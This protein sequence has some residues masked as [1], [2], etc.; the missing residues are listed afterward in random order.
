[1][2]KLFTLLLLSLSLLGFNSS[3]YAADEGTQA[4]ATEQS[5]ANDDK[6]KKKDGE[7]EP[8]CE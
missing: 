3:S 6:K 4:I 5:E 1:M 2:N 8:E 7:E